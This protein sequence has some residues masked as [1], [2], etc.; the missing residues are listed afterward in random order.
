MTDVN[1]SLLHNI[2][3]CI[4]TLLGCDG[5]CIVLRSFDDALCHPQCRQILSAAPVS[6]SQSAQSVPGYYGTIT[7]AQLLTN[8]RVLA[9]CDMALQTGDLWLLNA[10]VFAAHTLADNANVASDTSDTTAATEHVPHPTAFLLITPLECPD[11]MLGL[12]FCT[13]Y[14]EHVPGR[15]EQ[16]FLQQFLPR[17]SQLVETAL[18]TPAVP[19][20]PGDPEIAEIVAACTQ[21]GYDELFSIIG[22]DL[23]TPLSVIKGY[24]GLLQEYGF[25]ETPAETPAETSVASSSLASTEMTPA[26]RQK[27]FH[28]IMEQIDHLEVLIND[29]LDISRLRSGRINLCLSHIPLDVLCQEVTQ[30]MQDH[31]E[32]QQPGRYS[33]QCLGDPALP[34]VLADVHRVRQ[35]ITNLLENAVKYSPDGGLIEVFVY[36]HC[37]RYQS[38]ALTHLSRFPDLLQRNHDH[39]SQTETGADMVYVTVCDHGIG[40]PL[41]QQSVLFRPFK[42]LAHL[43]QANAAIA[44]SGL[45]LYISRRLLEAMHGH[46]LLR[47]HEG[48][49][50][51]VTFALPIAAPLAQTIPPPPY[52]IK[53]TVSPVS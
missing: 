3:E 5:A 50:T 16:R 51:S 15:T 48:Q 52:R 33:I 24:A 47:S 22:H 26:C 13:A 53:Y 30:Q 19:D 43:S 45:G 14:A 40:I 49:G 35:V 21:P 32:R 11:G 37:V 42:R 12:L 6:L 1:I 7:D 28:A 44:G 41:R 31:V 46:I 38:N 23:R 4:R 29:L 25:A 8:E 39:L 10:S 20:G 36:T 18:L 9:Y 34:P 2:A 27:Y 17:I